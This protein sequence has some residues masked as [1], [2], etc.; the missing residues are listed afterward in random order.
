MTFL[1]NCISHRN[2]LPWIGLA[3]FFMRAVNLPA[4]PHS[5]RMP[6][7]HICRSNSTTTVSTDSAVESHGKAFPC[8]R[9]IVLG[10]GP[11]LDLASTCRLPK[12]IPYRLFL[13]RNHSSPSLRYLASPIF[14]RPY[15]K[16]MTDPNGTINPP[17]HLSHH[18]CYASHRHLSPQSR[19][20]LCLSAVAGEALVLLSREGFLV[21]SRRD[22]LGVAEPKN[23]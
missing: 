13:S 20:V 5:A 2:S 23:T 9:G 7:P 18:S 4:G 17:N 15:R 12:H 19:R 3:L 6:D 10:L 11:S 16:A 1:P 22:V 8:I 14:H 21:S